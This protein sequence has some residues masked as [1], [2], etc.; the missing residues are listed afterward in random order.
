MM[1]QNYRI[2]T[3]LK[4]L[5][6]CCDVIGNFAYQVCFQLVF[7]NINE[8]DS[9]FPLIHNSFQKVLQWQRSPLRGGV[10]AIERILE[11]NDVPVLLF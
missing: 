8:P 2:L 3:F 5:C 4:N 7:N 9:V 6:F 10:R 11:F 1:F